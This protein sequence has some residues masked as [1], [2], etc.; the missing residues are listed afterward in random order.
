MIST[1][2]VV[3]LMG[4][5]KVKMRVKDRMGP[6]WTILPLGKRNTEIVPSSSQDHA[7]SVFMLSC[8]TNHFPASLLGGSSGGCLVL[9]PQ[10]R[11][12][13]TQPSYNELA[14]S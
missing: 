8:I 10:T 12:S 3:I 11:M 1:I 2:S 13:F 9:S 4:Q 14:I 7:S 5:H 6:A